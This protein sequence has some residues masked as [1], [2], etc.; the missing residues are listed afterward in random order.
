MAGFKP[1]A[2]IQ[3]DLKPREKTIKV[4]DLQEW[5][6]EGQEAV[7][8]VRG[9]VGIEVA[10]YQEAREKNRDM[11]A[12]AEGLLSSDKVEI[13]EAMRERLGVGDD[14]V[15]D[16]VAKRSEVLVLGSVSPEVDNQ[17]AIKLC[18]AFPVL[19][20]DITNQILS[21]TGEGS[22]LGKSQDS[23]KIQK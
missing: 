22:C 18:E 10:Q 1:D 15:P 7:W 20:Y 5:F 14:S 6:E 12:I 2:F 13:I 9:L 21:L 4:P 11:S 16:E 23:G 8:K 3:A 17:I 19:F